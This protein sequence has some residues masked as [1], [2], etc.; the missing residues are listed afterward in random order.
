MPYLWIDVT[1]PP[2]NAKR[3]GTTDDTAAIQSA[4]NAASLSATIGGVSGKDIKT[5]V[6]FP[7]GSYRCASTLTVP[8][9]VNLLGSPTGTV[10]DFAG[11]GVNQ[12]AVTLGSP[13]LPNRAVDNGVISGISLK[14][15]GIGSS[16]V[17]V[18]LGQAPG[19]S[20]GAQCAQAVIESMTVYDFGTGVRQG[21]NSYLLEFRHCVFF[22]CGTGL[23]D[24]TSLTNMGENIRFIACVFSRNNQHLKLE[25]FNGGGVSYQFLA[26]SFDYANADPAIRIAGPAVVEFVGGHIE[27][28]RQGTAGTPLLVDI[29]YPPEVLSLRGTQIVMVNPPVGIPVA[30]N[31]GAAS[32]MTSILFD[33]LRIANAGTAFYAATAVGSGT[34]PPAIVLGSWNLSAA[35]AKVSRVGGDGIFRSAAGYMVQNLQVVGP[36]KPAIGDPTG[37][38]VID[39][40]A[41]S[42]IVAILNALRPVGHGLIS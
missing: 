16:T 11:L 8:Y 24:T 41:R 12:T 26:C 42:A 33:N 28:D 37:G 19:T 7:A 31:T 23:S 21:S 6:V 39:T 15:P 40:Q 13:P 36:R 10:L 22:S 35:A 38:T 5:M 27:T 3:D 2:F 9:N 14:G 18:Q 25:T 30:W 20:N 1:S 4:L 32:N 34:Q 17:G 29:A